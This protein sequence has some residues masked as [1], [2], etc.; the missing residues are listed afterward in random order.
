MVLVN[1]DILPNEPLSNYKSSIQSESEIINNNN[2]EKKK[3]WLIT[4]L[5]CWSCGLNIGENAICNNCKHNPKIN[6]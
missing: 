6:E 4:K 2:N 3:S 5:R 1:R